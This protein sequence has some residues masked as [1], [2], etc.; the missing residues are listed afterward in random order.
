MN[1]HLDILKQLLEYWWNK[2]NTTQWNDIQGPNNQ[3][4]IDIFIYDDLKDD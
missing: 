1:K 2:H 4:Y 3:V